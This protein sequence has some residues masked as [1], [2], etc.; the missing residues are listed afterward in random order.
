MMGP[1]QC[2]R[3][4]RL[5]RLFAKV[6]PAA[7]KWVRWLHKPS[8]RWIRIPAGALLIVG[9]LLAMLPFF[10]LWMLPLGLILLSR[11]FPLFG[12]LT[13]WMLDRIERYRPHWFA[14]TESGFRLPNP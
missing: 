9:G 6:Y 2:P 13:D 12:R 1:Q 14:E 5:E 3:L 4:A 11:E 7:V 8:S 10:G